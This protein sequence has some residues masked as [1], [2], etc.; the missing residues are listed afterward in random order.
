MTDEEIT[1][2]SLIVL[3]RILPLMGGQKGERGLRGIAGETGPRGRVGASGE[4]GET[5]N[6]G[7]AGSTGAQGIP[8]P[9]GS[10]GPKGDVGSAG[11]TGQKGDVGLTGPKG[12][13]GPAGPTGPKGDIGPVGPLGPKGD[14]G[15]VGPTA[16]GHGLRWHA[17]YD[18][19]LIPNASIG[20]NG[21]V[22]LFPFRL[23]HEIVVVA[24]KI[25]DW[26]LEAFAA[27]NTPTTITIMRV[28]SPGGFYSATPV[29]FVLPAA[30]NFA[31]SPVSL[32]VAAGDRLL[33]K[34]D[35]HWNHGG[36]TIRAR[37]KA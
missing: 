5:G 31:T 11:P 36:L 22:E 13:M 32:P 9:P 16:S 10:P 7:D 14:P 21:T 28:A 18:Q 27:T 35:A 34:S 19:P 3:N 37:L 12:D 15:P 8:G 25:E 1:Q 6:K 24:G 26:R 17:N 33:A 20:I 29:Q 30:S 23:V 2:L 4:R